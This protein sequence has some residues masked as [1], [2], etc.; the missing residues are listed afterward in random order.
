MTS[1]SETVR[2]LYR[3]GARILYVVSDEE[4]RAVEACRAAF[5]P[6]TVAPGAISRHGGELPWL[7][8]LARLA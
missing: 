3:T 5:A 4:Q 6:G 2:E 8:V 1:F 7:E